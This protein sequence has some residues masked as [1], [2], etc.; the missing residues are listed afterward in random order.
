MWLKVIL[1]VS[2]VVANSLADNETRS[3]AV[4]IEEFVTS[5]K[6]PE[7][8]ARP[9]DYDDED[10]DDVVDVERKVITKNGKHAKK[11]LTKFDSF[12][13]KSSDLDPVR[14]FDFAGDDKADNTAKRQVR[15]EL[16][17]FGDTGVLQEDGVRRSDTH[18]SRV[19]SQRDS[20]IPGVHV[21][22]EYPTTMMPVLTTA[23]ESRAFDFVPVNIIRDDGKETS[24]RDRNFGDFSD[25]SLVPAGTNSRIQVK[26]GPNGKDYEY[27]YVYYY[28]DEEDENKAST[29][30]SAVTN[31]YDVPSRTTS[32]PRRGGSSSNRNKYSSVERSST[33]EPASNEVIPNRNGNNRGRQL[34]EAEDVSEERLPTNTR[35]PPRSRSNHNTGTTEPSR[36]RGN[37]PRP[38]LDLVDSSSFRTH[39]EG[40]EFPQVLPKGPVRFL[41][42]TPNEENGDERTVTRGRGRP[43]RVQE[44]APVEE[45]IED[46]PAPT[47]RRRPIAT[48]STDVEVE[49]S[50]G[51]SLLASEEKE[52]EKE[53]TSSLAEKSKDKQ[54]STESKQE[55]EELESSSTTAASTASTATENP[56]TEYPS[57]MDKAALDLYAFVQQGQTNLVDA[58]ST[59]ASDSFSDATT[60]SNDEA[61]TDLGSVTELSATTQVVTVEPFTTTIGTPTEP[62][63]TTTPTTT[64]ISTTTTTTTTT[65]EAP[66]TT[67]TT[68]APAGRGKFRRPGFGGTT[69]SRNR[70]KSN[71]GGSTTTTEA[72]AEPTQRTRGR[73]G[74]N[75]SNGGGFK[76]NRPGQKQ[77]TSV[78]EDAVQK[79]SSSSVHAERPSS[80]TRGRFRGSGATRSVSTTTSVPSNGGST[81]SSS[82]PSG[83]S[84]PSFNK[85]NI[86]R[87]RGRPTTTAP[88]G[89][90]ESQESNRSETAKESTQES[91]TT[92]PK[93]TV[94]ARLP[95][96]GAR[97]VIKPG[98]RINLRPKPG[99]S[100]TT[101]TTTP[102]PE[103]NADE[104]SIDEPAGEG[105]EEE[106]HEAPAETSPPP[107]RPT[108][109]NPLNKLR[110]RN[111]IQVHPKTTTR[112]P[113]SL[114]SRRSPLLPRRK[115]T[116]A[117]VAQTSQEEASEEPDISSETEATEATSAE[118][119]TAASTKHE[120]TRGLGGLLAPRR[121][122]TPRR[123]GQIIS[124]E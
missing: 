34:V 13:K 24:F 51:Q 93:S 80:S 39:Q 104:S 8:I 76:R 78:E 83:I 87:R 108:T 52:D 17:N 56:T 94:R 67:T 62:T 58:S 85:L 115:V 54:A 1:L 45:I 46:V 68:Q 28:Y 102:S 10:D 86:N 117:P 98:A 89:S 37:R 3:K 74:G 12:D 42:V 124:R 116:E 41:G 38:G 121:R 109:V 70:I 35:F 111:R 31:S 25:V 44:P 47:T 92:A 103:D 106:T 110:N 60:L 112:T 91:V 26:K 20:V 122:I 18:R 32:A 5:H 53:E 77:S 27:E 118:T 48:V 63:T 69:G 105:T 71:G 90:E 113:V 4:T 30:D 19:Q 11:V 101:T 73:F 66:T 65:T 100:T 40:P 43:Q 59:E 29:A 15:V 50:K 7:S 99:Q 33:V 75:G 72:P 79:E 119:S 36:T 55:Y 9:S 96:T 16:E 57:S 64:T 23:R 6:V 97:P 49:P 81:A 88:N 123:P 21:S 84:R 95:A 107:A 22:D 14:R 82:G 114:A 120:E 2:C 61:T